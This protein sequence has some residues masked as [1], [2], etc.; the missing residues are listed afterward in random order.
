MPGYKSKQLS[1]F[2]YVTLIARAD[3]RES[4]LRVTVRAAKQFTISKLRDCLWF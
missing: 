4:T 3:M 2:C 1:R